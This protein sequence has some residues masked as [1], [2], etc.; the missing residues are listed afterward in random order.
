M[1]SAATA[2]IVFLSWVATSAIGHDVIW[3]KFE[4][5]TQSAPE[6]NKLRLDA[7]GEYLRADHGEVTYL[8][9]YAGHVSC[10]RD[11]L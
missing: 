6:K 5:L 7:L 11:Q 4:E 3:H 10:R 9:S 1:K 8:V 2:L